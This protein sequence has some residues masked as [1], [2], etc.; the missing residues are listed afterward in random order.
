MQGAPDVVIQEGIADDLWERR[1]TFQRL[2][3]LPRGKKK[4]KKEFLRGVLARNPW[5]KREEWV[6]SRGESS[7]GSQGIAGRRGEHSRGWD[8]SGNEGKVS[9]F[10]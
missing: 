5:K 3:S 9:K 4:G 6:G 10:G 2:G 8:Q 7:R 1:E